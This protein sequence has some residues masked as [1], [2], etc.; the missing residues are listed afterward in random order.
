MAARGRGGLHSLCLM[1]ELHPLLYNVY[2]YGFLAYFK[3]YLH[4][5]AGHVEVPVEHLLPHIAITEHTV[6]KLGPFRTLHKLL[7]P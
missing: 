2:E 7:Y 3:E 5:P 4:S 6:F 1:S